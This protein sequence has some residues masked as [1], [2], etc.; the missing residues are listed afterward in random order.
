MNKTLKKAG[1]LATVGFAFFIG[2]SDANAQGKAKGKSKA[3]DDRTW[4]KQQDKENKKRHKDDRE[5]TKSGNDRSNGM[6]YYRGNANANTNRN[7]DKHDKKRYRVHRNGRTYDTDERGADLLRRAVNEGYRQGYSVGSGD[8]DD[9]RRGSYRNSDL[10][11]SGSYGY[12]SYVDRDQYQHYF[13]E[14]FQRGYDDGYNNQYR[15]GSNTGGKLGILTSILGQVL[16]LRA[17]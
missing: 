14:G 15:Y 3:K 2:V 10:Y 13:R 7:H 6:G 1:A 11:R 16:N 4:S 8:R 12:E 17:Y 9:R 5:M